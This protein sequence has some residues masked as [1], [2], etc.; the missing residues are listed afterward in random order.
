MKATGVVMYLTFKILMTNFSN[1][2]ML[3]PGKFVPTVNRLKGQ[4]GS[5]EMYGISPYLQSRPFHC[6]VTQP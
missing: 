2:K 1:F 5:T 4:I 6:P 3:Y